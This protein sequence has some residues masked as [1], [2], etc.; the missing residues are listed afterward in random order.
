MFGHNLGYLQYMARF[1]KS[2]KG[3]SYSEFYEKFYS[4]MIDNPTTLVGKEYLETQKRFRGIL[5]RTE[6]W[7]R[8]IDEI[9]K[10]YCR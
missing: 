10:D 2:I 7:G 9:K 4:Y 1:L 8:S 6:Y 5:N 3:I